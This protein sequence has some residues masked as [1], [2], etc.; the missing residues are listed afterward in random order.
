MPIEENR[1][2]STKCFCFMISATDHKISLAQCDGERPSCRPCS[3][4]Q[5]DCEYVTSNKNEGPRKALQNQLQAAQV[6]V[7]RYTEILEQLRSAPETEVV[8]ILHRLRAIPGLAAAST[9]STPTAQ[10][11]TIWPAL[12]P[13]EDKVS[14]GS[15]V[16]QWNA[17]SITAALDFA[18]IDTNRFLKDS[19]HSTHGIESAMMPM[20]PGIFPNVNTNEAVDSKPIFFG[21]KS[22]FHERTEG[23]ASIV[24]RSSQHFSYCDA[25]LRHLD[26]NYWTTVPISDELA[27]RAISHYLENHHP[28]TGFFD[29]D[30]FLTGLTG[31]NPE[32]CTAF[33]FNA[34]LCQACVSGN[35]G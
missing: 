8:T 29:A 19:L 26:V 4:L 6:E 13:A 30:L 14:S 32:H 34:L 17:Q 33:L 20:S 3:I 24:A 1:R 16:S 18:S 21:K 12:H 25:R 27:A 11:P 9:F 10:P 28:L 5:V 31:S 35:Q 15:T 23:A 7:A 2:L 22:L